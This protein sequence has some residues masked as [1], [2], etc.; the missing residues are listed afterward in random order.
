MCIGAVFLA[1]LIKLWWSTRYA[2]KHELID[3]ERRAKEQ[4]MRQSGI[5]VEPKSKGSDIPFG[6]RAIESGVEVDGIWISSKGAQPLPA[7]LKGVRDQPR[8][9][10]S[11]TDSE[12]SGLPRVR[13]PVPRSTSSN[14]AFDK[15][16]A[17]EALSNSEPLTPQNHRAS[18]KPRHSSL[19]RFSSYTEGQYDHNTLDAL[20]G[21]TVPP[22][23]PARKLAKKFESSTSISSAADN[24]RSSESEFEDT[25]THQFGPDSEEPMGNNGSRHKTQQDTGDYFSVPLDEMPPEKVNPFAT[26]N[27]S[28]PTSSAMADE[29]VMAE[30]ELPLLEN[31]SPQPSPAPSGTLKANRSVRKVNSGFEVLPAGTFET[32]TDTKGKGVDRGNTHEIPKKEKRWSNKLTKKAR[33][34]MSIGRS[35]SFLERL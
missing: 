30:S 16:V 19:L 9:E 33:N 32:H 4:E 35:S 5:W 8:V 26:P 22:K 28:P 14:S 1:G 23:N 27:Q 15:A 11:S 31:E 29:Q 6:V 10:S 3:E 21:K 2:K 12:Q 18:Y 34:S 13:Q 7:K 17:A 20:E 24:E 25:L